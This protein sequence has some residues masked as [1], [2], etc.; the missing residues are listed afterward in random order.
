[1][2]RRILRLWPLLPYYG[3][4]YWIVLSG[5]HPYDASLWITVGFMTLCY[6]IF[7]LALMM[8]FRFPTLGLKDPFAYLVTLYLMVETTLVLIIIFTQ[9]Q[10]VLFAVSAQL[11]VALLYLMLT[12]VS[13]FKE[14]KMKQIGQNAHPRFRAHG[15]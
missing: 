4:M 8:N 11:V 1:M 6:G 10:S 14:D 13:A 5:Y 3:M 12:I 9:S 2:L 15:S 7:A